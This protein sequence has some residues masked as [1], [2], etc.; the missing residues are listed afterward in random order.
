M[1]DPLKVHV[2]DTG[3]CVALEAIM[4]RGGRWKAV[5]V[6]CLTGLLR[7]PEH[8]WVLWDTGY[9]P[10]LLEVTRRLPYRLYR[11]MTPLRFRPEQSVAAQ[12]SRL[13]IA[14][15]EI[16]TVLISHLHADHL[17][18]LRDFPG[19]RLVATAAA[20]EAT[21]GRAG[22]RALRQGYLPGLLPDDFAQRAELLGAFEGPV[23]GSLGPT[24]DLFGDGTLRLVSL[25][26][27]ARGQMGLLAETE[28]GPLLFA[29]DAAWLTASVQECRPPHPVTRLILDDPAAADETLDRLHEF[30]EALPDV[31]LVPTHCRAARDA[32]AEAG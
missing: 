19:A 16:R 1:P 8:G 28:R 24:H 25:P 2:L 9:A 17:C 30:L 29:A 15:E 12:L 3:S 21:N 27:H 13:G 20:W 7:H 22:M 4:I 26:G 31:T 6:P 5:H 11:W 14:P 23:V 18:G 32:M 10:R